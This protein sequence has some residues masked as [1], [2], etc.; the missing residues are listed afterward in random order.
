MK[1]IILFYS[2]LIL[3]LINVLCVRA[4][5]I[6]IPLDDS[7]VEGVITP[8]EIE[9]MSAEENEIQV[10]SFQLEK[11]GMIN[12]HLISHVNIMRFQIKDI[13]ENVIEDDYIRSEYSPQDYEL[14]LNR[15][16]YTLHI[17]K[18]APTGLMGVKISEDN[19]G[20]YKF[21]MK[22]SPIFTD[23]QKD[24]ADGQIFCG[25][26][27]EGFFQSR[28]NS[29]MVE[30]SLELILEK[31][32]TYVFQVSSD[33]ALD[34]FIRD[35]DE[36]IIGRGTSNADN[37]SKQEISLESGSYN[38]L[39]STNE[40]GS[41]KIDIELEKIEVD[42][43]EDT[44]QQE[45][46]G[47]GGKNNIIKKIINLMMNNTFPGTVVGQFLIGTIITVVGSLIV[48]LVTRKKD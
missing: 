44:T 9:K 29:N 40:A 48:Y 35:N 21:K 2:L 26:T 33:M 12:F 7:Y 8:L 20:N 34:Y 43:E 45:N 5:T 36:N 25:E 24:N 39:C 41:Y 1:K 18:I 13:D 38:V 46:I 23:E 11:P 3:L 30:K 6:E 14:I 16:V 31:K 19:I 37:N 15:G 4:E 22:Y 28:N 32:G 42:N 27:Y 17:I 10:Y 47:K